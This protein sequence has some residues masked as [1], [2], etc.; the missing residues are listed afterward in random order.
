[1]EREKRV[2]KRNKIR[3]GI[4]RYFTLFFSLEFLLS[5]FAPHD[6]SELRRRGERTRGSHVGL[7]P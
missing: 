4:S 7:Y 1:M 3:V 2:L 6:H 5:I